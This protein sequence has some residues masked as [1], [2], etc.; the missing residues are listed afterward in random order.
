MKRAVT[1]FIFLAITFVSNGQVSFVLEGTIGKYPVV[2]K[3]SK[4]QPG[5]F[6][7]STRREIELVMSSDTG[8][9]VILKKTEYEYQNSKEVEI[10]LE[11]F[12]LKRT[13]S[14]WKGS[15]QAKNKQLPVLLRP[16]DTSRYD[17]DDILPI[18]HYFDSDIERVY[19]KTRLSGLVFVK[20]SL[21]R[22]GIYQLQWVHEKLTGM[23]GF[24]VT[25]GYAAPILNR[26]NRVLAKKQFQD[27]LAYFTCTG[28]KDEFDY[29]QSLSNHYLSPEFISVEAYSS[30]FCGGPHPNYNNNSF[31]IDI[32]KGKEVQNIEEL[33]W[34]TGEK[35]PESGSDAHGKYLDEMARALVS[36]MTGLYPTEMKKPVSEDSCDYSDPESW[37]YPYCYLTDKGLYITPSFTHA[38][39][40]CGS[41]EFSWIPYALL[42]PYKNRERK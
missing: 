21:T 14:E 40:A 29:Q 2:L 35:P 13:G 1:F 26:V 18:E 4:D 8:N 36:I 32:K 22:S 31:T 42:S 10:A 30:S 15:W 38:E 11:T 17:F 19:N 3:L 16:V 23:S 12:I 24:R 9:T 33:Y 7:K 34:F 41:P 6:Y 28:L 39:H 25:S 20:D 5:Y 37:K 27:I